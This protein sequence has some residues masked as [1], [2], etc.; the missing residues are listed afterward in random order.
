MLS[1]LAT[2]C[3]PQSGCVSVNGVT[4]SDWEKARRSLGFLPQKFDLMEARTVR[5]N[6]E[7]AAWAR[8]VAPK[9]C[10]VAAELA[11]D[12]V[13]LGQQLSTRVRH[14]SGGFRQRVGFACAIVH[15]PSV[16]LLDEPTVGI[17]PIQ[18]VG[19]RALIADFAREATAITTTH[20]IEDIALVGSDVIV[21]DGG[22]KLFQGTVAELER[23]GADLH[24]PGLSAIESGYRAVV[25]HG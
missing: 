23:E 12:R 15:E 6:L 7:Y 22:R 10:A 24:E 2:L 18:S 20:V 8:G 17:D 1:I 9:E 11:A 21:L 14:L 25:L 19:L 16:L 3:R 4:I 5:A 13:G